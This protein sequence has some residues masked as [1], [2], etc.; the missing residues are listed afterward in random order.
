MKTFE[1]KIKG[2]GTK[3]E[4]VQ[5]LIDLANDIDNRKLKELS[6]G[7]ELEDGTLMTEIDEAGEY[8]GV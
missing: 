6:K 7:V 3:A 2:S 1:I 8:P 4:I 5:A